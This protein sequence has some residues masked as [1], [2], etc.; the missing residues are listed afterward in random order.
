MEETSYWK[1][2]EKQVFTIGEEGP[3]LQDLLSRQFI[4]FPYENESQMSINIPL[5]RIIDDL[6]SDNK[7]LLRCRIVE[8]MHW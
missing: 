3:D 5:L 6:V 2:Q 1:Y 4:Y 7:R 8:R